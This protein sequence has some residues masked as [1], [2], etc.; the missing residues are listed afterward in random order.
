MDR[1]WSRLYRLKP[2]KNHQNNYNYRLYPKT[3]TKNRYQLNRNR[4]AL[5]CFADIIH[6][7]NAMFVGVVDHIPIYLGLGGKIKA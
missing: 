3:S 4:S 6:V 2:K 5:L 7:S 1:H